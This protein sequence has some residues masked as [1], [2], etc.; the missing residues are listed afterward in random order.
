MG[1]PLNLVTLRPSDG[2][3]VEFELYLA[4][5]TSRGLAGKVS[6][7]TTSD[8]FLIPGNGLHGVLPAFKGLITDEARKALGS[9][10]F[11]G[12]IR[13][14]KIALEPN[15]KG[16]VRNDYFS[17]LGI[18]I[19]EWYDTVGKHYADT[20]K[21]EQQFER[22][23]DITASVLSNFLTMI[24]ELPEWQD[25][26]EMLGAQKKLSPGEEDIEGITAEDAEPTKKKKDGAGRG[27][28]G[29]RRTPKK[30]DLKVKIG[31]PMGKRHSIVEDKA[32]GLTVV[33]S[34]MPDH[35]SKI[36]VLHPEEGCLEINVRHPLFVACDEHG[37]GSL[38]HYISQIVS[39][40]IPA[41]HVFSS[42][43]GDDGFA[44]SMVDQVFE[45]TLKAQTYMTINERRLMRTAQS[46][47]EDDY[48][49]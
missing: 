3:D 17:E 40:A 18:A 39:H 36:Y 14:S 34:D 20:A 1:Q 22:Y 42:L 16:F 41:A 37:S 43:D 32:T 24:G 26:N 9:G 35:R 12:A 45:Y 44:S 27:G 23:Q 49:G 21:E 46:Q 8:P 4:P 47:T 48:E 7:G 33:C 11:E 29:G 2:H 19:E 10:I 31:G 25:L 6:F 5:R 38:R 15:R 13:S 28:R 30:P